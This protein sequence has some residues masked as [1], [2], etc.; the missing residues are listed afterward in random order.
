MSQ[1]R[2]PNAIKYTPKQ[3][4]QY[5]V[6]V[7]ILMLLPLGPIRTL[8]LNPPLPCCKRMQAH[9]HTCSVAFNSTGM[10]GQARGT[11]SL[12]FPLYVSTH[13]MESKHHLR[14]RRFQDHTPYGV[15]REANA[16]SGSADSKII[17][18]I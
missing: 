6:I 12:L 5:A 7:E 9:T 13:R 16:I 18:R 3:K 17:H 15:I 8:R 11:A 1:Q 2:T 10:I 4:K 14:K